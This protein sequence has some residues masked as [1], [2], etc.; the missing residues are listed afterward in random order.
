M[1]L[2]RVTYEHVCTHKIIFYFI[3]TKNIFCVVEIEI[4]HFRSP[5]MF[6]FLLLAN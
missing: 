3:K 5:Q 4:F 1:T 6:S 2:E